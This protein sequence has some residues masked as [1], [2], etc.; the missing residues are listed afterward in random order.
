MKFESYRKLRQ[1]VLWNQ[2]QSESVKPLKRYQ[3]F[4]LHIFTNSHWLFIILRLLSSSFQVSSSQAAQCSHFH[5]SQKDS[6]TR[7]TSFSHW[8][9]FTIS[10]HFAP[11][12]WKKNPWNIRLTSNWNNW[13]PLQLDYAQELK[14]NEYHYSHFIIL[15]DVTK[16]SPFLRCSSRF[17][18][19][20]FKMLTFAFKSTSQFFFHIFHSKRFVRCMAA[21]PRAVQKK[22]SID[23]VSRNAV[24][25]SST[26]EHKAIM[27]EMR[28]K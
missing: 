11:Q 13:N 16:A 15:I 28:E 10:F 5:H 25:R 22:S 1:K 6:S 3:K 14:Q 8:N 17:T 26:K 27:C 19:K 23:A 18:C 20:M 9:F 21:A 24:N 12:R 2:S 4:K 7:W